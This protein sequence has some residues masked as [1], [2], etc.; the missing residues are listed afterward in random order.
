MSNT[1]KAWSVTPEPGDTA[2]SA[3]DAACDGAA[4]GE[5][6]SRTSDAA[7]EATSAA[8]AS[9]AETGG[10]RRACVMPNT[11]AAP[12]AATTATDSATIRFI[13]VAVISR[14]LWP[15]AGS[16]AS[17]LI[18]RR[19]VPIIKSTRAKILLVSFADQ[20]VSLRSLAHPRHR[21]ATRPGA[22]RNA[23]RRDCH[24]PV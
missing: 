5:G 1:G 20:S 16:S 21:N 19:F 13:D 8:V 4:L 12:Q 7:E 10:S 23:D 2:G 17:V 18:L 14:D 15:I 24:T 9:P 11:S 3:A 6:T 22:G